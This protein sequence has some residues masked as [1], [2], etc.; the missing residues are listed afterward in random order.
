VTIAIV[1]CLPLACGVRF[2]SIEPI[3][4]LMVA[5]YIG[6][7]HFSNGIESDIEVHTSGSTNLHHVI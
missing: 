2:N 5:D 4:R 7:W 6:A 1:R 3:E